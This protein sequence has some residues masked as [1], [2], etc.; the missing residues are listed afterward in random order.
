M[1]NLEIPI[2]S[3]SVTV[4]IPALNEASN[5]PRLL[6][7]LKETFESLGYELPVLVINDGSTD[8]SPEILLNLQQKY[9]FLTVIHHSSRQG[10]T[11]V[12]KTALTEVQTDWIFW[13]Q[14]DLESDPRVDLP[15]LLNAAITGVDAVAGWR[16]NRGDGK[17]RTSQLA[18]KV[19]RWVFGMG[20]HDM[21]WIKLIR[22][23]TL[24]DLPLELITHRYLLAIMSAM[25]YRVIEVPTQ[26]FP[27]FSGVSKFGYGRLVTSSIDFV[28]VLLWFYSIKRWTKNPEHLSGNVSE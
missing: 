3:H 4:V 1:P 22:R 8:E 14:G 26:W 27:R 11:Q 21:N 28:R 6:A 12:W 15:A 13:G 2:I 5:L 24:A 25:G 20:I 9:P 23:D 10:V 19:C 7:F 16:Q 18:N 17:V